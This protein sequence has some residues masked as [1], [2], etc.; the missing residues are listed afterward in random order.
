MGYDEE[1]KPNNTDA[2]LM[3]LIGSLDEQQKAA[4]LDYAAYIKS[5]KTER[6]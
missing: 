4:V 5:K 3:D 1:S 2:A 6:F